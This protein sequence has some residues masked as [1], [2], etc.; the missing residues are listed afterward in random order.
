M[1]THKLRVPTPEPFSFI[2]FEFEG[3][4]EGAMEEYRRLT[5][6][7]KEEKEGLSKKEFEEIMDLMIEREPIQQDPGI[8]EGMNPAQKYI[9][10]FVRKSIGR[11]DYKN[12]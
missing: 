5:I 6:A 7:V 3:T 8:L 11:I 4:P 10:D 1:T 9:F 12:R 2:E